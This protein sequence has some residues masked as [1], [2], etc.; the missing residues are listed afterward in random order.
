MTNTIEV[1]KEYRLLPGACHFYGH[2]IIN[3]KG[4]TRVRVHSGPDSQGDYEV[5]ALD[6][7]AGSTLGGYRLKADYLAPLFKVGDRAKVTGDIADWSHDFPTG[8][9]V[10]LIEESNNGSGLDAGWQCKSDDYEYWNVHSSDLELIT[11]EVELPKLTDFNPGD[12]VRYTGKSPIYSDPPLVGKMG[13]VVGLKTRTVRVDFDGDDTPWGFFP[14]NIE[15]VSTDGSSMKV[16]DKA[17]VTGD[18]GGWNHHFEPGTVVRLNRRT[19]GGKG[20][21]CSTDNNTRN[22]ADQDL[23][24]VVADGTLGDDLRERAKQLRTEADAIQCDIRAKEIE[25]D[26]KREQADTLEDAARILDAA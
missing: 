24:P 25:R 13:T 8:T 5:T 20:W 19:Y 21:N 10:T 18:S 22:V 2:S 3:G 7:T 26:G 16:G 12:R 9:I 11:D 4:V 17:T 6:G 23:S 15:K 1:G 14:E